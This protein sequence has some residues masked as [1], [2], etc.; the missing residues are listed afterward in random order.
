MAQFERDCCI[1]GYHEYQAVWA[2]AVGETLTCTR[3][4]A[5]ESDMHAVAVIKSGTTV[6]HL[7]RKISRVCSIFLRRGRSIHCTVTGG[8]RYS[9]DLPQ[10]GLEIPCIW[11][12]YS[13]VLPSNRP[14]I[15]A[16]VQFGNHKPMA[17]IV[18]VMILDRE[19]EFWRM[20][21]T[22]VAT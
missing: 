4:P 16:G 13:T 10:G 12:Q 21:T 14:L 1:R 18:P 3:E 17:L 5:Y 11:V 6:G 20:M 9:S 2:A 22:K 19:L 8:R 7:P 15:N